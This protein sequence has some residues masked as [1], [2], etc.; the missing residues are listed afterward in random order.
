MQFRFSWWP[1]LVQQR[2]WPSR[3]RAVQFQVPNPAQP[4]LAHALGCSGGGWLGRAAAGKGAASGLSLF[5][6][7]G[8]WACWRCATAAHT[9]PL[10]RFVPRYELI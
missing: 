9:H 1:C 3:Q 6:E 5:F 7:Q 4:G 8:C 10:C 2:M